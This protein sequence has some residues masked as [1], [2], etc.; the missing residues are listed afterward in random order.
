PLTSG[1]PLGPIVP[2]PSPSATV[3]PLVTAIDPSWVSVTDQPSLVRIVT[4]LPL[5]GTVPANVTMPGAGAWIV[6]PAA[7]PTST[8]RCWPAVYGWAGSN[9]YPSRTGPVA[10]HVQA[11]AGP[12][13][14]SAR[15]TTSRNR[16]IG[17]H[18]LSCSFESPLFVPSSVVR[19]ANRVR[20]R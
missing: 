14:A 13:H 8:P 15:T 12:A 1:S 17:A 2:T 3:A 10:G 20:T 18:H 7:P 16:R 11:D 6:S 19:T 5:P 4:D 9:E